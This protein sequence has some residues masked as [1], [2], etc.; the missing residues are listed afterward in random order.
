MICEKI[1]EDKASVIKNK[2]LELKS[3]N[4]LYTITPNFLYSIEK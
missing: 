3:N 4:I 1:I 2:A